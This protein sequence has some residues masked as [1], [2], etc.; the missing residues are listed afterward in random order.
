MKTGTIDKQS[1]RR[2]S[3][4]WP[5]L[6]ANVSTHALKSRRIRKTVFDSVRSRI[7]DQMLPDIPPQ[8]VEDQKR[9]LNCLIDSLDRAL[10]NKRLSDQF[11]QRLI[12]N[13]VHNLLFN[14]EKVRAYENFMV[15]HDGLGPPG[16]LLISPGKACN[17]HCTGCYASAGDSKEKLDWD[18]FDEIITQAKELW[19][20]W[21]FT[22][23]GGEP[24]AYRSNGKGVLDMVEKHHDCIFLMYTNGTLI[25]QETAA[26]MA[27][28]GNLTPAISVEGM[29]AKTD[30]RRGD[31]VFD[32]ILAAMANLRSVGVPFGIS[33]TATRFNCAEILSDEVLDF[34]FE[35][36]GALY[37]W[38]FQYMPIGRGYTLDLMPTPEQRLWMWRRAWDI[39]EKKNRFIPD[40][41]TFGTTSGGCVSSGKAGG[42]L[43]IDW[44]GK[45]MPCVFFPYSPVNINDA[46]K[47]GKTL[48]DVWGEPFFAAL[49]NWQHK[50]ANFEDP[51][52]FGN[53]LLPCPIRDH[54]AEARDIINRFEPEPEDAAAAEALSD[55]AY[56]EG[57]VAYDKEL[58][59]LTDPVWQRDYLKPMLPRTGTAGK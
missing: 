46:F 5:S 3:P 19:G 38:M 1:A 16:L 58:A 51:E 55:P 13:M 4:D 37:A 34:F 9:I 48:N 52:H 41:W 26:R 14:S 15:A 40:F 42:Y 57:L 36:Q 11:E 8:V 35:E 50:Y 24:L 28:T 53:W 12:R 25:D 32:R 17:L 31:G 47:A 30:E 23:S 27:R 56:Y 7:A 6:L 49:R 2:L 39:M 20:V 33:L 44:N 43:Y 22:I 10:E 54:H 45:V 21:F 59:E 29:R 18:V